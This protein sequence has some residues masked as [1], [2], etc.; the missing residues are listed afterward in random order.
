MGPCRSER[1]GPQI[2]HLR[3]DA[4]L[5]VEQVDQ[6]HGSV[7]AI[8]LL[9]NTFDAFERAADYFDGLTRLKQTFGRALR[10]SLQGLYQL[11]CNHRGWLPKLTK[12]LTPK[13]ERIGDQ[14]V[15]SVSS[16]MNK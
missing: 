15:C 13:V 16:R 9:K 8:G 5:L 14:L 6:H 10:H 11:V 7:F 1:S 4:V 2:L 12:R 3:G